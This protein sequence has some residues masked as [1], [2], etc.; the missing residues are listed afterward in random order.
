MIQTH[1]QARLDDLA[2]DTHVPGAVLGIL[3]LHD[4][5]PDELVR[6]ATGTANLNTNRAVT[7]GTLF[8]IGSITKTWTA[9]LTMQLVDEG[10]LGLDDRVVDILPGFRLSTDELTYGVTI[11]HLLNHTSGVDGDVF[12]DTGRGDDCLEKYLTVLQQVVQIHPVGAAWSYCNAGFS[13]LGRII[14][15]MT[16]Q[17]WDAAIRERLYTPLAL[18]HT[19][20]LPEDVLLWDAALGNLGG[21]DPTPAPVWMLQRN[22]GPAGLVTTDVADLLAFARLHLADGVAADGTR[23]L[24]A[25]SARLMRTPSVTLPATEGRPDAWGLG[26][27]LSDW[28]GVPA[29]GHDGSTLGQQAY[30]RFFPGAGLAIALLTNG[31]DSQRLYH[32][33]FGEIAADLAGATIPPLLALPDDPPVLRI[34]EWVGRYERASIAVNIV[35]DP[36]GPLFCTT[37]LDEVT[38]YEQ[39]AHQE[40]RLHP[41]REG[42]WAIPMPSGLNR[43]VRFS[44]DEAGNRY[45]HA[46]GRTTR[47]VR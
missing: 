8:Q 46:D 42:L 16:G 30:L 21:A 1:W 17:V 32:T 9:T 22:A 33:L 24:S 3:Q 36:A 26:F 7:T 38:A 13:I 27:S 10:R 6:L 11:R 14:E 4:D 47:A 23:V 45:L 37:A 44:R 12:V 2:R 18:A 20:T 40:Y 19:A 28:G 41:V 25:E 31:S 34:T 15:V 29:V 39:G 43:P 35:D 5:G